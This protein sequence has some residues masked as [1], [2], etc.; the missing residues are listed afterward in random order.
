MAV[1]F[2]A[3]L[4]PLKNGR[5][6]DYKIEPNTIIKVGPN[7]I[8][9]LEECVNLEW[10]SRTGIVTA[11]RINDK[12]TPVERTPIFYEGNSICTL[13]IKTDVPDKDYILPKRQFPVGSDVIIY[14]TELEYQFWY[15]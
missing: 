1:P 15:Y 12:G 14:Y 5:V 3:K 6:N 13:P 11:Q 10:N 4:R 8:K 2:I 7:S 9:V